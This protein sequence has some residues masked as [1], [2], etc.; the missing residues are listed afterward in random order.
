MVAVVKQL[1]TRTFD[2]DDLNKR[3]DGEIEEFGQGG[4]EL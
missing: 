4:R 1:G 3:K 2:V